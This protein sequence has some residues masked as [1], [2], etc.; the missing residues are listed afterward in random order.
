MF[1]IF[2]CN[3]L[4]V[5]P[6]SFVDLLHVFF[7]F[8]LK[9]IFFVV[10]QLVLISCI[11]FAIHR[12]IICFCRRFFFLRIVLLIVWYQFKKF[13]SWLIKAR[14]IIQFSFVCVFVCIMA[15]LSVDFISFMFRL[16]F[17]LLINCNFC[18]E[19]SLIFYSK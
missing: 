18:F 9:S 15:P 8:L 11:S 2:I 16:T 17:I 7:V 3:I 12:D 5:V 1:M 6:F 13:P 4:L 10:C 19:K 14:E